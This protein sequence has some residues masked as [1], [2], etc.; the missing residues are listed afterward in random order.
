MIIKFDLSINITELISYLEFINSFCPPYMKKNNGPWGGWSIT[1]STGEIY[2]GWQTGEKINDPSISELEKEK[3]KKQFKESDFNKPTP[4]YNSFMQELISSLKTSL[5]NLSLSRVRIALL[6][7]HPENEAY[8][9][10]DGELHKDE[11]IFRLHIPIITNENCF[12]EYPN[13]RHHLKSDGSVYL[14]DI[15][16][17]HRVLN[18]SNENRFHL[19]ADV[20]KI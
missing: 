6:K 11:K 19:I 8:W 10:Q 5:P 7:P 9:H 12:F 14:V 4:L 1:S 13:E 3:I 18:L 20:R 15:S 16:R 2:D 17:L